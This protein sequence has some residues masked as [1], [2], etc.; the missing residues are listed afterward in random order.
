MGMERGHMSFERLAQSLPPDYIRL[1]FAQMCMSYV[2]DRFGVTL[3]TYDEHEKDPIAAKRELEKWLRGAGDDRPE[4]GLSLLSKLPAAE[5]A[6][7]TDLSVGAQGEPNE[8]GM[9]A[10][11]CSVDDP[12]AGKNTRAC[13]G[14]GGL[15]AEEMRAMQS[16]EPD[17]GESRFREI[18][19]S[20]VG[21]FTN[22][23]AWSMSS[24][25][26]S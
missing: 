19:Y 12:A 3:V 10:Q 13:T 26:S 17:S 11:F 5:L 21:G 24:G 1:V 16:I 20:H 6:S 4:A 7:G 8:A 9:H 18:F 22:S 14:Q 15:Q 25:F 23:A 2:A